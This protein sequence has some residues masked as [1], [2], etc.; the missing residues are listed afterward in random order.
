VAATFVLASPPSVSAFST[1]SLSASRR[2]LS[3]GMKSVPASVDTFAHLST[4]PSLTSVS[5]N[6][7]TS[8]PNANASSDSGGYCDDIG[9]LYVC[10]LFG[11]FAL[12]LIP[13]PSDVPDWS[14]SGGWDVKLGV[15]IGWFSSVIYLSSRV[16]Q[17]RSE[18]YLHLSCSS[19]RDLL[20]TKVVLFDSCI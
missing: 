3:Y 11:I 16:P 4:S 17:V 13:F 5:L 10:C 15:L 2:L 7:Q 9:E 6:F 20:S 14:S 18:R 8:N 19:F 1:V 12:F